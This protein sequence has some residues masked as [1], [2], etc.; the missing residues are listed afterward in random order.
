MRCCPS[1]I[2]RRV[3][4]LGAC[5]VERQDTRADGRAGIDARMGR[6][7]G[8]AQ[9]RTGPSRGSEASGKTPDGSDS[10]HVSLASR[11]PLHCQ[12][13]LQALDVQR[14]TYQ[15]PFASRLVQTPHA[16]APEA[17]DFLDPAI[18]RFGQPLALRVPLPPRW[19]RQLLDHPVCRR[20]RVRVAARCPFSPP[21]P[22]P[23]TRRYP[24]LRA[25]T[26]PAHCSSRR[27]QVPSR[28]ARRRSP[29]PH[30]ATP[31]SCPGRSRSMS[32]PSRQS[33]DAR[34]RPPPARCSIAGTPRRRSS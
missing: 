19:C 5:A 34:H 18:G 7:A 33:T 32:T 6:G 17:K 13:R 16:E 23:H 14:Q 10:G 2:R 20:V 15:V 1:R 30:R 24:A 27:P 25:P 12:K 21:A 8:G 26:S 9:W 11:R 22:A 28:A 3:V 31:S 4:Q 29:S